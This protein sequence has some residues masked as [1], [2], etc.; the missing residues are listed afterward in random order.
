MVDCVE[1][2]TKSCLSQFDKMLQPPLH[3]HCWLNEL[4]H[5]LDVMEALGVDCCPACVE[6]SSQLNVKLLVA[7]RLRAPALGRYGQ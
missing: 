4:F 3:Q 6:A 2:K 7:R 1:T 5:D